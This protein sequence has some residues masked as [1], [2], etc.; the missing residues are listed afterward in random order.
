MVQSYRGSN[1]Y[2]VENGSKLGITSNSQRQTVNR[3]SVSAHAIVVE[4]NAT[5]DTAHSTLGCNKAVHIFKTLTADT[6][7]IAKSLV[8]G[9]TPIHAVVGD[10][11]IIGIGI[12]IGL[13][14][15]SL[16]RVEQL[17]CRPDIAPQEEEKQGGQKMKSNFL[18]KGII[19]VIGLFIFVHKYTIIYI[20]TR[21][22]PQQKYEKELRFE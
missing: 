4:D 20:N 14:L 1:R 2:L 3:Y 10:I 18:H 12:V 16:Q 5:D 6:P 22:F 15:H 21:V 8:A 17:V 7:E 19:L 13:V 11:I 9:N